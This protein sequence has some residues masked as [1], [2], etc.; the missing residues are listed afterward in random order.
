[1]TF[2]STSNFSIYTYI[3]HNEMKAK[4]LNEKVDDNF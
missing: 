4:N 3:T 1:M 2:L